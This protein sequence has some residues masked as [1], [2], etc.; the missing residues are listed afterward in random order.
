MKIRL[1]RNLPFLI[2]VYFI[3]GGIILV[4]SM[5]Y[6]NNTLIT[7]MREQAESTTR[8]FSSFTALALSRV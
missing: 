8:L 2:R 1:S 4:I 3:V 7:R 6:Y 5:L